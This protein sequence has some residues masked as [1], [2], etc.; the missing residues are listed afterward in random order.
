M[1]AYATHVPIMKFIFQERKF[2]KILEFGMGNNSTKL[3]FEN[4]DELVSVEMQQQHWYDTMLKQNFA[5]NKNWKPVLCLGSHKIFENEEIM[6][7]DYDLVFVDGHGDSRPECINHFLGK[8]KVIVAH[9]VETASYRWELVRIPS[10]YEVF[11]CNHLNPA[12]AVYSSDI[13]LIA[14][15]R[16]AFSQ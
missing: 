12:T 8:S 4:C 3:L 15:L 9:D 16:N 5:K 11:Y 13:Q 7:K 2:R 10:D 1:D 14:S 6:N